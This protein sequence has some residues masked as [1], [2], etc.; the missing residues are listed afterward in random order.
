MQL[1]NY[2]EE[3]GVVLRK[4]RHS[5][6]LTRT[7][8]RSIEFDRSAI[9]DIDVDLGNDDPEYRKRING[10]YVRDQAVRK[11]VLLRADGRCEHCGQEGFR[12][13]DGRR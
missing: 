7:A 8:R 3:L 9:N 1:K 13:R 12:M 5:F 2:C 10:S 11:K 6:W 4:N